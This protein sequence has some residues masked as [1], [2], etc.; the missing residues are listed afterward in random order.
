MW[1]RPLSVPH[2]T[3]AP[4]AEDRLRW[5]RSQSSKAGITHAHEIVQVLRK[6]QAG[7]FAFGGDAW[8]P[9]IL[10]QN[11]AAG[12]GRGYQTQYEEART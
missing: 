12:C 3:A 5:L 1:L 4:Q 11:V 2:R 6:T 9:P 8:Y 10:F 7:D